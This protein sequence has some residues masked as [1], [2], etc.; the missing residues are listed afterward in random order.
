MIS[1]FLFI[2]LAK[3]HSIFNIFWLWHIRDI[4]KISEKYF[5]F[6]V[7]GEFEA[8]HL[9]LIPL[10]SLVDFPKQIIAVSRKQHWSAMKYGIF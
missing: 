7:W 1:F 2:I 8:I 10:Q 4:N 5:W 3:T 9:L 6:F